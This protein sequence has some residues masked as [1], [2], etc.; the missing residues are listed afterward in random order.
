MDFDRS[1]E[2]VLRMED[3]QLSGVVTRDSGGVT[4][5]G[6]SQRTYPAEDIVNMPL[7]KAKILYHQDYW[8]PASCDAW[9]W[10]LCLFV[11]DAA[12]NQGVGAA[13]TMLQ[14]EAG[15]AVDGR[16]GARTVLAIQ[17]KEPVEFAA[18]YLARRCR[19]YMGTKGFD[20][21]GKGWLKRLFLIAREGCRA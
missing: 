7:D 16:V 13:L 17:A 21:Y 10:P 19:R 15:V 6:I 8:L 11:F 12:V 18:L 5:W 3:P 14:Q 2:A 9:K 1:L 4:R 20:D